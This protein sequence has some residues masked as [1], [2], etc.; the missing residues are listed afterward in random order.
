MLWPVMLRDEIPTFGSGLRFLIPLRI[1]RGQVTLYA[2][3]TGVK[4]TTSARVWADLTKRNQPAPCSKAQV[5]RL[6][7]GKPIPHGW[8][9]ETI[10]T[11]ATTGD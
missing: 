2:P 11:A 5:K 8:T 4:R 6:L 9:V 1:G 10:A 7:R 3:A